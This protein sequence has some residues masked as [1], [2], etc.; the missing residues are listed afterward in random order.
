MRGKYQNEYRKTSAADSDT[1]GK[2]HTLLRDMTDDEL[3][4]VIT[5]NS[6]TEAS[7]VTTRQLEAV[8]RDFNEAGK[9]ISIIRTAINFK[10][11]H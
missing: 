5:G 4:Q 10:I 6:K 3:A 1:L 2:G 8:I 11:K 9:P 7:D